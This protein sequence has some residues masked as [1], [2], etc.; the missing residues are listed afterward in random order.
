MKIKSAEEC[1]DMLVGINLKVNRKH[2][3]LS[4]RE[5]E[6]HIAELRDMFQKIQLNT[7]QMTME[8]AMKQC[9]FCNEPVDEA[10]DAGSFQVGFNKASHKIRTS[11]FT[12][13]INPEAILKEMMK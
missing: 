7:I 6:N 1:L 10:Y 12:A 13:S 11:L 4:P 8:W 2:R 3:P 9:Q 5:Q